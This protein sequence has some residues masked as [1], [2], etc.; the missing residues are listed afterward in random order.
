MN[1]RS[2]C[3]VKVQKTVRGHLVRKQHQ[4]RIQGIKR[5]KALHSRLF[6]MKKVISQLKKDK[7]SR[8]DDVQKLQTSI[9]T[10]IRTI[11]VIIGKSLAKKWESS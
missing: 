3:L 9:D 11:K 8:E 1:Y 2:K 6:E 5:I 7:Q 4:P 10:A